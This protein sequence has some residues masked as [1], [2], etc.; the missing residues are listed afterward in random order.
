MRARHVPFLFSKS[1]PALG[2]KSAPNFR[3]SILGF[4]PISPAKFRESLPARRSGDRTP[5]H[6]VRSQAPLATFRR[7]ERDATMLAR[8]LSAGNQARQLFPEFPACSN[9]T[10][11]DGRG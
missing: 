7:Y 8:R 6:Q 2:L 11:S 9:L 1:E 3:V 4:T 10:S 5:R